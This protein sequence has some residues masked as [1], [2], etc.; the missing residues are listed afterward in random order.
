M[1]VFV[2]TYTTKQAVF[3]YIQEVSSNFKFKRYEPIFLLVMLLFL[4][5]SVIGNQI[6]DKIWP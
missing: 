5:Y 4:E 1:C 2:Y 6:I 3:A